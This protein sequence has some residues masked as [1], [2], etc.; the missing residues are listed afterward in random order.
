MNKIILG[1]FAVTLCFIFAESLT[2]NTCSLGLFGKCLFSSTTSC[3]AGQPTCYS[4]VATFS[5]IS[6]FSGFSS[7]GC[8][9][10][11][12]C[13]STT[14]STV[15]F[16]TINVVKTCCSTDSCNQLSGAPSAELS[17]TAAVGAALVA[18]VWNSWLH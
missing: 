5:G 4:G 9:D 7:L 8:S 15:F 14:N 17:L 10:T 1:F 16:A 3:Q 6:G 13:N 12:N 11:T 18:S 2:C